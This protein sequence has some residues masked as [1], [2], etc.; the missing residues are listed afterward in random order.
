MAPAQAE[1]SSAGTVQG[2]VPAQADLDDDN[3]Y[4]MVEKEDVIDALATFI[5]R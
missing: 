1:G 4:V 2:M 3:S 5:A